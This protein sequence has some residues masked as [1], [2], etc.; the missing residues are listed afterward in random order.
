MWSNCTK[1]VGSYW[2]KITTLPSIPGIVK[3]KKDVF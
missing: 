2:A 1:V 3:P